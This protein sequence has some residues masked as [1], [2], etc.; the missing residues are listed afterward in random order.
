MKQIDFDEA[1]RFLHAL[2]KPA[3]TIRLRAF[4]H[5]L[6][7]KKANDAGRKGA[8]SRS[9]MQQWQDEGRGVYVVI[10]DGGDKDAEITTCR[11][12]FCE[13]D[14]RPTEWQLTAWKELN[15]PEPTV[16]VSTGG[17]SIHSYWVL[18]DPI[19]PKYWEL[20]QSRLLDYADADR[21]IKNA[22]RVMRLP[23]TYHAGGDGKLGDMCSIVT[24]T[25][26]HYTVNKIEDCLPSEQYYQH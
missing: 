10:N 13:W 26:N 3:G 11:A 22:A 15:L 25:N 21:S 18:T 16:Q 19:T 20:I 8:P 12:F 1:R 6:N 7:P 17:K 4:Y 24:F 2:G 5:A 9:V 23:G 14:D